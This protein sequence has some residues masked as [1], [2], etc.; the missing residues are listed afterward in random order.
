[1]TRYTF[2]YI[3]WIEVFETALD[4]FYV[5]GLRGPVNITEGIKPSYIYTHN[6]I[7]SMID[8]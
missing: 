3:Y 7:C 4:S 8:L 2:T 6:T 5:F 1:M